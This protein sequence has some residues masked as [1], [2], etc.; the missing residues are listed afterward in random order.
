MTDSLPPGASLIGS[1]TREPA[2]QARE[3]SAMSRGI[4][5]MNADELA[6]TIERLASALR[7]IKALAKYD[8]VKG[9]LPAE[10]RTLS[11]AVFYAVSAVDEIIDDA[12]AAEDL[13]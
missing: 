4:D 2:E 8:A 6:A 1:D 12:L 3:A 10:D 7:S 13:E 5:R 11:R 9:D